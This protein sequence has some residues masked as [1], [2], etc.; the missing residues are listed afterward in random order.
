MTVADPRPEEMC[1][2][3]E[4]YWNSSSRYLMDVRSQFAPFT[5]KTRALLEP[6]STTKLLPDLVTPNAASTEEESEAAARRVDLRSMLTKRPNTRQ[7]SRVSGKP[8]ESLL[9]S[10]IRKKYAGTSV[11][12]HSCAYSPARMLT[13]VQQKPLVFARRQFFHSPL[14]S[15]TGEPLSAIRSHLGMC[16]GK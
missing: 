15:T 10:K 5:V 11:A 16:L 1:D 12:F 7:R 6:A 3:F 14:I 8:R 2:P 13:T 4:A 9:A